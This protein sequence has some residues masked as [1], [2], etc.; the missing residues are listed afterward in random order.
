MT[1]LRLRRG[2]GSFEGVSSGQVGVEKGGRG[3]LRMG[4]M[5]AGQLLGS[6]WAGCEWLG[7]TACRRGLMP[8][9]C[10]SWAAAPPIG[11]SGVWRDC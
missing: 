2:Q 6:T 5:F 3:A 4:P 11:A 8:S 10:R 7:L 1:G 9:F